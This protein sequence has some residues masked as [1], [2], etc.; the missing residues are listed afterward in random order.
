M[1]ILQFFSTLLQGVNNIT[2]YQ[3]KAVG[4]PKYALDLNLI[5]E[6]CYDGEPLTSALISSPLHLCRRSPIFRYIPPSIYSGSKNSPVCL[7]FIQVIQTWIN[8]VNRNNY[9]YK[10]CNII[11][12]IYRHAYSLDIHTPWTNKVLAGT[13][14][15][16]NHILQPKKLKRRY[17]SQIVQNT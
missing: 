17:N 8:K 1:Q 3:L 4:T 7:C 9:S 16:N 10:V 15:K 14:C 12:Q 6:P 5:G 13:G 2:S 11:V